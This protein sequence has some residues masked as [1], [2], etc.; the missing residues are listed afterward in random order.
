MDKRTPFVIAFFS[1]LVATWIIATT[2]FEHGTSYAFLGLSIVTLLLGL[3]ERR[4][5]SSEDQ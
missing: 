5:D 1:G 2:G 3:F 4:S